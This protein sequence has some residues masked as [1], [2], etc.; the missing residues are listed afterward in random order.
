MLK[1]SAIAAAL[2]SLTAV[3]VKADPTTWTADS[4]LH[5]SL[6]G[7][8]Y[9][10]QDSSYYP[11][12]GDTIA[13]V[14][15][16]VQLMTQLTTRIRL[17]GTDCAQFQLVQQAIQQ[18]QTNLHVFPGIY[19]DGN[20]TTYTRQRDQLFQVLDQYGLDNVLGITVG[21]E[22][23][24]DSNG[25]PTTL[26]T[27]QT[28]LLSKITDVRTVL[29]GKNYNKT[30]PVGSADAGSM[31][32]AEYAAACDYVMANTHPFFSGVTIDGA[33][34]WTSEYLV[35]QEPHYATDANKTLYSAEIGWP[36]DAI[37]GGS[38]NLNGSIASVPNTQILLDTFVCAANTNITAS[39][40]GTY[41][42]GY[43]WFEL[44]DQEWKVPDGGAEPFWGV[45]DQNRNLKNLTI[46]SCLASAQP[47]VGTMGSN[48]G[49]GATSTGTGTAPGSTSGS[50]SG[51]FTT[52]PLSSSVLI[53]A[54]S[55]LFA[56]VGGGF[57]LL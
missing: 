21:N 35:D 18:T 20:D 5:Q 40:G 29:A 27:A 2:V 52:S 53:G 26:A 45:F 6:W 41:G 22:Y 50:H 42:H 46:P 14:V 39:P 51:A 12:C 1:L 48:T 34:Q 49:G 38:L 19:I 37:A 28:Y 4:R 31:I 3:V 30:I 8:A 36:T 13:E 56:A 23:L 11:Q 9:T 32:T 44:F 43:F 55:M 33:A 54:I 47:P 57:A 25:D 17:Y 7:I 24:L 15:G 16:D 10:S